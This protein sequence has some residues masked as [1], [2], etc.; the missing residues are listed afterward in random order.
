M[1]KQLRKEILTEVQKL[2]DMN[3]EYQSLLEQDNALCETRCGTYELQQL[4][5]QITSVEKEIV[6]FIEGQM[7]KQ[8]KCAG[9]GKPFPDKLLFSYVDE[10]NGAITKN[11]PDYCWRCYNKKYPNDTIPLVTIL[12]QHGH[13]VDVDFE[14]PSLT[15]DGKHY[16]NILG[17]KEQLIEEYNL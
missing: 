9:C 4:R 7:M 10:N 8:H 6:N 15:I 11:S 5:Q 2:I 16:P 17:I 14:T 13:K 12:T 1:D 3:M